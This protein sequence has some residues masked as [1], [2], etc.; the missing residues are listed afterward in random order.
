MR[1]ILSIAIMLG[2]GL[3][4]LAGY[5]FQGQL[6][7]ILTMVI[8]WGVVVLGTAILIGIFLL[9]R[10]HFHKLFKAKKGTGLSAVTV[11]TFFFILIS[12]LIL[13]IDHPFFSDL[14]LNIQ[15]P[16]EASLLAVLAVTLFYASL[17]FIR[18]QGWTPL[19]I[20]F[21]LSVVV[22]LVLASNSLPIPAGS[23]AA[24]VVVFLRRLP[25]AGARGLLI[26]MA[27]GGMLVGLRVLLAID[28][29]YGEK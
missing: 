3:L 29:P 13:P 22:S 20:G 7:P 27:L 23:P 4:I 12:G 15:I 25:L 21:V 6:A 1:K 8:H 26:G 28:R 11:I 2:V 24:E 16:V 17:C 18:T 14:I 9:V 5:F 19:S 10:M